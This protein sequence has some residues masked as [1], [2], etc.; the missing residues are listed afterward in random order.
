MQVLRASTD[1]DMCAFDI[2]CV[3]ETHSFISFTLEYN[4]LAMLHSL[5]HMNLQDLLLLGYFVPSAAWAS[6]LVIY[7]LAWTD[8]ELQN[9]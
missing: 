1:A 9:Y 3:K 6:I 5:L 7:H 4:L 2:V 8:E